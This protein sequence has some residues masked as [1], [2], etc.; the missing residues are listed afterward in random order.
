[1]HTKQQSERRQ[2]RKSLYDPKW[3]QWTK[4]QWIPSSNA[5][6]T[7]SWVAPKKAPAGLNYLGATSHSTLASINQDV[8]QARVE[9]STIGD[10]STETCMLAVLRGHAWPKPVGGRKGQVHKSFAF[11]MPSDARPPVEW[12]ADDVKSSVKKL[13]KQIQE[14][15]SGGKG[16]YQNHGVHRY[17]GN[18]HLCRSCLPAARCRCTD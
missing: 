7:V 11:D 17:A 9:H 3:V 10:R 12:T 15:G 5:Q 16:S 1:M 6:S 2:N 4:T 14:C 8:L 13:R 18:C